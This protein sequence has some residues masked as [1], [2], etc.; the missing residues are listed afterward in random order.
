[1]C[2]GGVCDMLH[3]WGFTYTKPT[4]RLKKANPLKQQKFLQ[5]LNGIKKLIQRYDTVL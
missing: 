1:M 4:C 2:R 5:E 3:R